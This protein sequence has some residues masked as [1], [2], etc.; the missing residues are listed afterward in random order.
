MSVNGIHQW[1]AIRWWTTMFDLDTFIHIVGHV[2]IAVRVEEI[3]AW[4]YSIY[5]TS[6]IVPVFMR[7]QLSWRDSSVYQISSAI[8][9]IL[10]HC[11]YSIIMEI[12]IYCTSSS[13]LEILIYCI[14]YVAMTTHVT[15][16]KSCLFMAIVILCIWDCSM[17]LYSYAEI[18]HFFVLMSGWFFHMGLHY[19]S[20]GMYFIMYFS[21]HVIPL[22]SQIRGHML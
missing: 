21:H 22:T 4:W 20:S 15:F 14:L 8:M 3:P 17:Y 18:Y 19:S 12:L 9:E 10:I 6:L 13:T 16:C 5:A 1:L 2:L 11:V 7:F